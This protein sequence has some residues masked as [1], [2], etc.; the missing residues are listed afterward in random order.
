MDPE[1]FRTLAG[2]NGWAN[3]RLYRV[4]RTLAEESY[5]RKRDAA[6]FGS[7]HGTLNHILLGDR[8]WFDRVEGKPSPGITA[9]D[10]IL[11]R[12]FADLAA[13][14]VAEDGRIAEIAD[15][16]DADRL[17]GMVRYT[18]MAGE[19]SETRLDRLLT[20]VFNHQTHHRGQAH[21]LLL[22]AGEDPPQLDLIYYLREA[23]LG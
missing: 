15:G 20:H 3:Q 12:D 1:H 8:V 4:C 9:L 21:A 11:Y 23:G 19:A 5:H 14:R 10:Q 22:E 6:F 18:N 7:I 17:A 13:A 16:L 2:Y